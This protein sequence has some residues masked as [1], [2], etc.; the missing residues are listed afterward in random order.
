MIYLFICGGKL[1]KP[2]CHVMVQGYSKDFL[3]TRRYEIVFK[4]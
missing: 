4:I 2:L 3:M 1:M